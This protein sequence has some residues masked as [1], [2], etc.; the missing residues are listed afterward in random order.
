MPQ[1]SDC[2]KAPE[3]S[4]SLPLAIPHPQ[5]QVQY[6][7][8]SQLPCHPLTLISDLLLVSTTTALPLRNEHIDTK[9]TFITRS[10]RLVATVGAFDA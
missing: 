8:V 5:S 9:Y 2:F 7:R 4:L 10:T 6:R 3:K 1:P